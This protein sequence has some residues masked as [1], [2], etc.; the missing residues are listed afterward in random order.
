MASHVEKLDKKEI[1][2]IRRKAIKKQNA[3]SGIT[4]RLSMAEAIAQVKR[5]EDPLFKGN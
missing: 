5:E 2:R 4:G 3:S 1:K